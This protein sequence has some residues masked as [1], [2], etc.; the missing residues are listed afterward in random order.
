MTD[1]LSKGQSARECRHCGR[2][3]TSTFARVHGDEGGVTHRCLGCD[4]FA[5][6]SSGSAAGLEVDAPDPK[7]QL[8]GNRNRGRRVEAP[9]TVSMEAS[10]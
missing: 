1:K 5:R 9:T 3:V 8:H 4:T 10:E 2:H 7:R 6:I